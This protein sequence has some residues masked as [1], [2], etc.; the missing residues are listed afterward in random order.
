M[1]SKTYNQAIL[2]LIF[3]NIIWGAASPIFKLALENIPPFTLAFWRFFGAS[4]LLLPFTLKN[5]WI[6]RR[7]WGKLFLLSF[8]GITVNIIF[9]FWG[10]ERAPSINAPIISS[11]GP[12]L[13]YIFAILILH[14]K[15][16]SKILAGTAISLIGVM[17]IIGQPLIT[18]SMDGQLMGNIFFLIA[19]L[20]SVGHAVVIKEILTEYKAIT[21]TFWS[22]VIGSASFFPFYL[23]E[24][25]RTH[26]LSTINYQGFIGLI[27]GI[28]LSSAYAYTLYDWGLKQLKAQDVGVF[29][30][31]DPIAAAIIAI[32]LLHETITSLFI[33]GSLFVFGGIFIAEGRLH[34]HPLHKLRNN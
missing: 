12:V 25:S 26:P 28:F 13:L 9:F 30:Y 18:G 34:W 23:L 19:T 29:S 4:L 16:K 24:I 8:L 21:L 10:L 27:F 15:A 6:K 5:P 32:P 1:L 20:G 17:I 14:E 7:D 22:F 3:A 33:F 2:A 11:S 31:I